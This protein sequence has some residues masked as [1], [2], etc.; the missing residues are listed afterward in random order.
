M[1]RKPLRSAAGGG[2]GVEGCCRWCRRATE[3]GRWKT[4]KA[5]GGSAGRHVLAAVEQGGAGY[6]FGIEPL[7]WLLLMELELGTKADK[8]IDDGVPFG[9]GRRIGPGWARAKVRGRGRG[10]DEETW[11]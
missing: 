5:T 3:R 10:K 1:R 6:E 9:G 8:I 7:T 2:V 11:G 4:L